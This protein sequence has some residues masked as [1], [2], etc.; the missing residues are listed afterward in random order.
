MNHY[1]KNKVTPLPL[2]F[3]VVHVRKNEDIYYEHMMYYI[4]I[5]MLRMFCIIYFNTLNRYRKILK[6]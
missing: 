3:S 6:K 1:E 2:K 5:T 4:C